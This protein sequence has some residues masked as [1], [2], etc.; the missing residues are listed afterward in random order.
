MDLE[1]MIN[2]GLDN[3]R[4]GESIVVTRVTA[5]SYTVGKLG[6]DQHERSGRTGFVG[7]ELLGPRTLADQP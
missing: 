5:G 4:V 1:A 3:L 2:Y 6:A 7:D